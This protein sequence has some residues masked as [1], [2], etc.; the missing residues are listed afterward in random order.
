MAV[1]EKSVKHYGRWPWP[2]SLQAEL[3]E[4]LKRLEADVIALDIIYLRPQ[5]TEEDQALSKSL[6][7]PGSQVIGGYFF[8]DEQSIKGNDKALEL[9]KKDRVAT[10]KTQQ[11]GVDDSVLQFPYVET[12]QEDL[13][14]HFNG[15]GFFNYLPDRDGLIRTA[16]L[17]LR[18]EGDYYPSLP[19]MALAKKI[20]QGIGI[21]LTAEGIGDIRLG[22]F[23]IPVDP[24]GRM[25][26][27]FYNRSSPIPIISAADILHGT[28]PLE[29]I[30]DRIVFVGV[31]E[32][33]I[34]DV[35]PTPI[36][37]SF[38][39]VAI[40][41]TA[42]ANILQEF[43]LYRDARTVLIDVLLVATLPMMLVWW[44]SRLQRSMLMVF[45][46]LTTL[47]LGWW[48]YY[49]IITE[50]GLIISFVYPFIAI[51]IGYM[52]FQTYYILVTQ[53]HT[54]F[55]QQAFSTYVSPIL[56]NKLLQNPEALKL[57]GEKRIITI[58]FSDIRG[59]TSLSESLPPDNLV[60][61]LNRYLAPM[62]RIV[63]DE[64]GTLDK[65]IGDALM[66]FFNAPLSVVDHAQRAVTAAFRMLEELEAL[67]HAFEMEYGIK[68]NIGI[69]IHTGEAVVGNMGSHQRFDYTAIG[70]SVNLAARLESIT[71]YYGVG[72]ILSESTR[73]QMTDEYI[74]RK[75]DRLKVKGKSKVTEIYELIGFKNDTVKQNLVIRFEHALTLYFANDFSRAM[76]YFID[77]QQDYP[78]DRPTEI[79]IERCRQFLKN[80][81]PDNWGG[82]YVASEK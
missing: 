40:H 56:V 58:L 19:L 80:P 77:L 46:L 51:A 1:D 67:N 14:M 26:L 21:N 49:M 81:P 53:S 29:V 3:I 16:A 9:L 74:F 64:N 60:P 54:R 68:L 78:R 57:S 17:V 69:G 30:K 43:Y 28:I 42:A 55:L 38:P 15:F 71:K 44:M 35:R 32:V 41:A 79:F 12:N 24:A 20:N 48:I 47:G 73:G 66:A 8:R 36:E 62:T 34:A 76:K 45:A 52:V 75:L 11:D 2:R 6:G 18:Y 4:R 31:T 10:L 7:L 65:Y 82:V 22:D 37:A 13:A 70:D 59:F 72:I 33:G 50:Y 27:N 39:G 61:I 5:S 63:M 23:Q 25:A